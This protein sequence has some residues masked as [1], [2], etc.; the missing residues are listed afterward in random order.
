MYDAVVFDVET[1]SDQSIFCDACD[2]L[3]CGYWHSPG[4]E[5]CYY[6]LDCSAGDEYCKDVSSDDADDPAHWELILKF[7]SQKRSKK[8][9]K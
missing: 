2:L 7:C 5:D 3:A 1:I 6:C 9:R 4:K 8:R